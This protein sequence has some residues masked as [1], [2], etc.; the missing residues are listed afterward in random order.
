MP[1]NIQRFDPALGTHLWLIVGLVAATLVLAFRPGWI[2]DAGYRCQLQVLF[3]LR[4]PFC[5]MTRDFAA[6]LHGAR[7]ALNPCSWFAAAVVYVM[8][9]AGLAVAWRRGRLDA[10]RSMALR[11]A[12]AVVLMVML[13][14]NNLR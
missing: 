3:G 7:P 13:V 5:G 9:P 6:I 1:K 8:Y 12:M 11:N 10:F 4:C 2:V 14:L